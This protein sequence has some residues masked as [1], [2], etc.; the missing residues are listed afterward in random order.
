MGGGEARQRWRRRITATTSSGCSREMLELAKARRLRGR[1]RSGCSRAGG[2]ST[3]RT[4]PK[5]R[6][7]RGTNCRVRTPRF[8][9]AEKKVP[10]EIFCVSGLVE[11]ARTSSSVPS[12]PPLTVIPYSPTPAHLPRAPLWFV[13]STTTRHPPKPRSY[14]NTSRHANAFRHGCSKMLILPVFCE[15]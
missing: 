14:T 13:S 10:R 1:R 5:S 3:A 2:G 15:T 8:P 7:F 11:E 6:T 9:S 12:P 4:P